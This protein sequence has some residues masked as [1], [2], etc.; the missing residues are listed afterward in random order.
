MYK[1][2]LIWI[3]GIQVILQ[4]L[5]KIKQMILKIFGSSFVADFGT[6]AD[7]LCIQLVVDLDT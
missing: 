3:F 6:T 2:H 5:K 7:I 4:T 1:A